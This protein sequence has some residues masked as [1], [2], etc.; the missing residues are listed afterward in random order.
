M[1]ALLGDNTILP[2]GSQSVVETF[3]GRSNGLF[4]LRAQ[5]RLVEFRQVTHPEIGTDNHPGIAASA[6]AVRKTTT[7]LKNEIR[8]SASGRFHRIPIDGVVQVDVKIRDHRPSIDS[9]VRG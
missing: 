3:I 6:H 2:P 8:V 1:A 9:H 5:T 7:V 4:L